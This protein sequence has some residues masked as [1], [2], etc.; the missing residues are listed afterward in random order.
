TTPQARLAITR[1]IHRETDPGTKVVFVAR[2]IRGLRQRTIHKKRLREF[3]IVPAKAEVQSYSRSRAP[4]VLSA[5]RVVHRS[6]SESRLAKSLRIVAGVA[7]AGQAGVRS[8]RSRQLRKALDRCGSQSAT[9]RE[10][11]IVNDK[12]V[13]VGIS[14]RPGAGKQIVVYV[15]HVINVG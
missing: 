7:L 11:H 6:L 13:D 8:V 1:E 4:I 10:V 15:S 5:E 3:F 14:V 9:R 12:V 2:T